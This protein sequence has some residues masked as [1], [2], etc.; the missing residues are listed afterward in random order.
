MYKFKNS[1][2]PTYQFT[3]LLVLMVGFFMSSCTDSTT[4]GEL[5]SAPT[6]EDVTFTSEPDSEN[7]NII[8][9]TNT[10]DSFRALWDFGNGTTAEGDEVIGE[11]PTKGEYTV[12]LTIF[13]ESGH[14]IDSSTVTIAETNVAMLDDPNLNMLTGGIDAINGKTWVIDSTQIGHMGLGPA[15]PNE[16]GYGTPAWW[17]AAP[18][19]KSGAGLYDDRYTFQLDDG[20]VYKQET[21]GHVFLKTEYSDAEIFNNPMTAGPG[22]DD[23]VTAYTAPENQSFSLEEADNGELRLKISEPSF[24]GFYTGTRTYDILELKEN[25]MVI[26]FSDTKN[27][28]FWFHRLIPEGYEHP[29]EILP[30]KSEALEDNFDEEGNVS[31]V[32]DQIT[33]FNESYDDPAPLV[34][35]TTNKVA[36][37]TK[38]E[39]QFENVYID[40]GY[41]L[42]LNERSLIRLRA[43][44]P[45]YNDYET[46]DPN[47]QSWAPG[48]LLK[49]VEVKLHN[50]NGETGLGGNSWQTQET[51]IQQVSETGKWVDLEFDFSA[52]SD[53]EDFDR[54]VIQIGGEG[55]GR[56]GTF[57]IDD[58][59]LT[60]AN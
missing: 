4:G 36:K 25:L 52:V 11:F 2:N 23:L 16:D 18:K 39:G 32:T 35:D 30:Y 49:Q 13:T 51:V 57:F 60:S 40:L 54:I 41:E 27:N 21:N 26:R 48:N 10:S 17:Q 7:P 45:S 9:F 44:L 14:A 37:Y 33:N 29:P 15:D 20:F 56:T 31:W 38:G 3:V 5:G 22:G 47:A 24:M 59:E 28:F 19:A 50:V 34:P 53:R 12:S 6:S 46:V 55:H 43:Y 1:K 8:H 42:N 58:F